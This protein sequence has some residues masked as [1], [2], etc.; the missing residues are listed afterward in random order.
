MKSIELTK[1]RI[2]KLQWGRGS[3]AAEMRCIQA[4]REEQGVDASMGPRLGGRG[5]VPNPGVRRAFLPQL[6]WG[7]GSVAAEIFLRVVLKPKFHT[8][9]WGRG[10]VAAEIRCPG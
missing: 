9:Q 1:A 5:D 6:Q 10:S 8:L 4:W 7:R 2:E 3:V